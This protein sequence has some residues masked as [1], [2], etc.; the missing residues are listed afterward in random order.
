TSLSDLAMPIPEDGPRAMRPTRQA[1]SASSDMVLSVAEDEPPTR[2]GRRSKGRG[3]LR[4]VL[5]LTLLGGAGAVIW[6]VLNGAETPPAASRPPRRPSPKSPPR[7]RSDSSP[8]TVRGRGGGWEGDIGPSGS[9]ASISA[10]HRP[11][12]G[13]PRRGRSRTPGEEVFL[14]GA[15]RGYLSQPMRDPLNAISSIQ[16][17]KPSPGAFW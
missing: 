2:I 10:Q 1:H 5:M 17:T 8:A 9:P 15:A 7:R 6:H 4:A 13:L 16:T 14:R 12:P 3:F 11:P